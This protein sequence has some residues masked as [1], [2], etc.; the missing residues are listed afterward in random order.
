MQKYILLTIL[1]SFF[2]MGSVFA[3]VIPP[4]SNTTDKDSRFYY[5]NDA[6]TNQALSPEA[7]AYSLANPLKFA[8]ITGLNKGECGINCAKM[9][10][11]AAKNT[12]V[13]AGSAN[14][15]GSPTAVPTSDSN[16]VIVT[17]K[18]PGADCQC[19]I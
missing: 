3:E 18:V 16:T 6:Q 1:G 11:A 13:S 2:F 4:K 10:D 19:D 12:S 8:E 5:D 9:L 14:P 17:E 15:G 7:R